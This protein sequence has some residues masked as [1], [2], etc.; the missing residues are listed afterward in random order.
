[1]RSFQY[2]AL[3]LALS[4]ALA[5][6]Q[7]S[8]YS[9]NFSTGERVSNN[10][11]YDAGDWTL[12]STKTITGISYATG[13][14]A[15]GMAGTT[16]GLVEA[17]SRFSNSPLSLNNVNDYI[18]AK[19]K[20][21]NANNLLGSNGS[22]NAVSSTLNIGLFDSSGNN[23]TAGL[24]LGT[25]PNVLSTAAGSAFATGNAQ[26]WEGYNARIGVSGGA[27]NIG[28]T[29]PV[30][31]GAGT[32][33]ANQ[34]L[35]FGG[36]GSGAFN[37]PAAANFGST[38][39]T[40]AAG[41][42]ANS[43]QYT[44]TYRVTRSNTSEYTLVYTLASADETST[45]QTVT[46]IATGANFLTNLAFDG[47]AIGYRNAQPTTGMTTPASLA[48][49]I[50]LNSVDITTNAIAPIPEASSFAAFAGLA[51]LGFAS[52]RRRRQA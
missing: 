22:A 49:A 32:T 35:L 23:P 17:Q 33:S 12:A 27:P 24:E 46:A 19:I 28:F 51:C 5:I 2:A 4:P 25:A 16:S 1:M 18:Q 52:V 29:R 10:A 30:Q 8:V 37:N 14:F 36:A 11:N 13:S 48:T 50:A 39:S 42:L 26:L 47:V 45:L 38:S 43:T 34:D 21:T 41:S 15:F 6:A 44:L 7:T 40:L 20:F 9:T 3:A 31:S